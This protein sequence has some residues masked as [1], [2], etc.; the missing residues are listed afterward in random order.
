MKTTKTATTAG[1]IIDIII[2]FFLFHVFHD[3]ANHIKE[4]DCCKL[5][6][7]KSHAFIS[8]CSDMTLILLSAVGSDFSR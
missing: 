7:T 3:K 4:F 2:C 5:Q 6:E 1:S 8:L